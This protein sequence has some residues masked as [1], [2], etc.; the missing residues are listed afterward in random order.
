MCI[1][2]NVI[3]VVII[4]LCNV[5]TNWVATLRIL[6]LFQTFVNK[7]LTYKASQNIRLHLKQLITEQTYLMIATWYYQ[8]S[9]YSFSTMENET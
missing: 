1:G 3:I 2:K 8:I 7:P 4:P 6:S 9:N 5:F